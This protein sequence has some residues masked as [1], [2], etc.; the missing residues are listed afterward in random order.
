MERHIYALSVVLLERD[1]IIVFLGIN[2]KKDCWF[3]DTT[4]SIHRWNQ[5]GQDG[6]NWLLISTEQGLLKVTVIHGADT[7]K[8]KSN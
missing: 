2:E 7:S 6:I 1:L 5:S 3:S 8:T 4:K